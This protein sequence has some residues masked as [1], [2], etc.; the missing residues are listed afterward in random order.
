MTFPKAN[1][2]KIHWEIYLA[3]QEKSLKVKCFKINLKMLSTILFQT[4]I[5][6]GVIASQLFDVIGLSTS[7]DANMK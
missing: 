5:L 4:V 1:I 3:E 2:D 7:I 6:M